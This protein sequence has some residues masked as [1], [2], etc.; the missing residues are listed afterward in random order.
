MDELKDRIMLAKERLKV[1][2]T[3]NPKEGFAEHAYNTGL[4]HAKE[5]PG[6]AI[7]QKFTEERSNEY[8][9][10]RLRRLERKVH[11]LEARKHDVDR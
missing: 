10:R 5:H 6:C 11:A 2:L 4:R 7:A 9:D 1:K 8:L 3:P